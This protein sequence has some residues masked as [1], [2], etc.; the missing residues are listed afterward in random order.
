MLATYIFNAVS[1]NGIDWELIEGQDGTFFSRF[2]TNAENFI[3]VADNYG[4]WISSD[5][6]SWPEKSWKRYDMDMVADVAYTGEFIL[7]INRAGTLAKAKL[8][9]LVTSSPVI[10]KTNQGQNSLVDQSKSFSI[11]G[12]ALNLKQLTPGVFV[13]FTPNNS[14]K[15]HDIKIIIKD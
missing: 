9:D 6:K 8:S 1:S 12:K 3:F 14:R 10:F 5:P 13:Q 11:L 7:V 2:V 4:Y 15:H